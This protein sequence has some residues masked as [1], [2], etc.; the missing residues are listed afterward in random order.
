M[1]AVGTPVGGPDA[2]GTCTNPDVIVVLGVPLPEIFP[3][4]LRSPFTVP[5]E[6]DKNDEANVL[7][8]TF[9]VVRTV[10]PF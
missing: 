4:A 1:T 5:P 6:L 9:G 10:V 7:N 8:K 3:D 2:F